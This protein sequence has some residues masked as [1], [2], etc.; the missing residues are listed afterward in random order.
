MNF[1]KSQFATVAERLEA[2]AVARG[3]RPASLVIKDTQFLDVFS[4]QWV[5]G[6]VAIFEGRIVGTAQSYEGLETVDGRGFYLVPGFL[7]AHVHVESSMLTPARFQ[8]AVLPLGTTTAI[9][10]PHEIANVAGLAGIEWALASAKDLLLDLLVMI[11]SCVPATSPE[12][13]FET[14]GAVLRAQD[15][16]SFVGRDGVLGLAEMMNYPG[17]LSGDAD[18]HEKLSDFAHYKK[19]GH[20]PGLRGYDLNAYA[21]AGIH[22]CHESTSFIE[23]QEKMHKGIHVLIREGSCAKDADTLLPLIDAYTSASSGFCSDDRN[24]L[25]I[26]EE[27]HINFTIQKGLKK[28]MLAQDLFRAASYGAA[29]S[30]GLLDRGAIAP[31]YLADFVLIQAQDHWRQGFSIQGVWKGGRKIEASALT[32]KH[33]VDVPLRT[34]RSRNLQRTPISSQDLRVPVKKHGEHRVRVIGVRPGQI[35]TDSL[36]AS[37]FTDEQGQN[38]IADLSKDILKIAVFERHHGSGAAGVGFVQGFGLKQGAIATSINHDSHN[39]IVVGSDDEAMIAAVNELIRIDGG[40]VVVAPEQSPQQGRW[41]Y[42]YLRLPLGGLMTGED[43]EQI[44]AALRKLKA[45]A[46]D[47]G[48]QLAEPFLQLS[49]L[50]LPV[51]PSL[52]ITDQGLVDVLAFRKTDVVIGK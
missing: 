49:F 48:C 11:P 35:L 47:A 32:S 7:D 27:G 5:Q 43:P 46:A 30:Y 18:V 31:G 13:E 24:P 1:D 45:Q 29:R 3:E 15:L 14:S 10:D 39:I 34:T 41:G 25:D 37:L 23:A 26:A 52:K 36:E 40:I 8:Q 22:S 28:G 9:W 12:L 16:K 50:A 38:L 33:F 19:D 42:G 17:V 2:M 20:C 6:D 51:I 21:V 4:G 44:A